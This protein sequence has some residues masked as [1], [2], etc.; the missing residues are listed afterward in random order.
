MR[1]NDYFIRMLDDGTIIHLMIDDTCRKPNNMDDDE[2]I[3]KYM[4]LNYPNKPYENMNYTIKGV[5]LG[6][7]EL[8]NNTFIK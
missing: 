4:E 2:I 3:Q 5:W 8:W 1:I 7:D 6:I